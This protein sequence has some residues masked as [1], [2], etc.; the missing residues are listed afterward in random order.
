M[1]CAV[2][3]S[4]ITRVKAMCFCIK[5]FWSLRLILLVTIQQIIMPRLNAI[6]VTNLVRGKVPED[7]DRQRTIRPFTRCRKE[8]DGRVKLYS[9]GSGTAVADPFR[10]KYFSVAGLSPTG[11]VMHLSEPRLLTSTPLISN[12]IC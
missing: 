7:R 6:R 12:M 2:G 1:R 10:V 11:I 4:N 9:S 3:V 8:G 5:Q